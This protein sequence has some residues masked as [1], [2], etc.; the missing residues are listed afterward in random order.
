MRNTLL[1][2]VGLLMSQFVNGQILVSSEFVDDLTPDEIT[3]IVGQE[4]G[5]YGVKLY[6]IHYTM[7]DHNN[8]L[9]T[10]SGMIVVPNT[11]DVQSHLVVYCHG[12]SNDKLDVPS[13]MRGGLIESL[14]FSSFGFT[15]AAPD[16]PGL[17]EDEGFHPYINATSEAL[18]GVYIIDIAYQVMASAG[19]SI[20]GELFIAGYSQGGHAGMALHEYLET[21]FG[22]A[23]DVTAC[24][25]GSGPYSL[26]ERMRTLI[27]G[28]EDY[29]ALGFVPFFFRGQQEIYGNLYAELSDVFK[30]AYIPQI[31]SFLD[32]DINL[33]SVSLNMATAMF[34]IEGEIKPKHLLVDDVVARLI[35][36][37]PNDPY[38]QVLRDNDVH[39]YV[40]D[41]PVNL[42]YCDADGV[43]PYENTIIARDD[44]V[45]NGSTTVQ[46]VQ[47]DADADHGPCAEASIPLMVDF[48]LSFLG[49][50]NENT[51]ADLVEAV[52]PNPTQDQLT[53]KL[54]EGTSA[55]SFRIHSLQGKMII[56]GQLSGQETRIDVS[57]L[58]PGSYSIELIG[59]QGRQMMTFV[60]N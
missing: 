59:S 44:M 4:A 22:G 15:T 46:A 32:G 10:V 56:A 51:Q 55:S 21:E 20:G 36:N 34:V 7:L 24:A 19:V 29:V 33:T 53:V 31:E 8:Q 39:N 1:L 2:F 57:T 47:V 58:M 49:S 12:T 52:F 13:Q 40:P 30:P 48:F 50:G 5:P 37:D 45:A 16:Y 6:K 35:A 14:G 11:T 27:S 38:I 23:L 28:D 17:G 43:V 25:F 9:D 60:K 26:S 41:V 54:Q 42:Y 18:S 3:A